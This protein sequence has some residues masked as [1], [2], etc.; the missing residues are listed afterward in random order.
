[1]KKIESFRSLSKDEQIEKL[2][3]ETIDASL[4]KETLNR[5]TIADPAYKELLENLS[6]NTLALHMLPFGVAPNVM[7]NNTFYHVPMVTEESSVIAAAASA[8]SFWAARGGITAIVNGTTK[9]GQ[10]H[11]RIT[12]HLDTFSLDQEAI[13]REILSKTSHLTKSMRKRGGGIIGIK[14]VK[15]EIPFKGYL[16]CDVDFETMDAMGANFINSCLEAIGRITTEWILTN[17][18]DT[19]CEVIMAILS[20]HYPDCTVTASV[21]APV[22]MMGWQG[23]DGKIMAER[24]VNAILIAKHEI[25]RAVTHN[26]GIMNGVDAVVLA[27]GNDFRAIE[28][29]CHA[30]AAKDGGYQSLS[31]AWIKDN[32]FTFSITLP[33]AVGTVGGLTKLHPLAKTALDILGN[34][35]ASELMMIIASIGL[36][37]NFAAVRALTSTGIQKGHMKLHLTNLL[38]SYNATKE[39]MKLAADWFKDKEISSLSVKEFIEQTRNSNP[40]ING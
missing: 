24:F 18:P 33:L 19:E 40:P 29:A 30:F 21:S 17:H 14:W 23:H 31:D 26:K 27:T 37:S 2:A 36:M 39:E 10:V 9:Q 7:I 8:S 5:F 6:E 16:K 38:M 15:K 32:I 28:A 3:Q 4:V 11:F 25:Q 22:E 12:N 34:P 13:N 20:N 1:M 35:S